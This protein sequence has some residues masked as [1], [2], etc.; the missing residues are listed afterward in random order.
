MTHERSRQRPLRHGDHPLL[1]TAHKKEA[2]RGSRDAADEQRE[3]DR[4]AGPRGRSCR[5]DFRSRSVR[6]VGRYSLLSQQ[7]FPACVENFPVPFAREFDPQWRIG[8]HI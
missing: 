3:A 8:Q 1:M 5:T 7:H 6:Q 4:A 2:R